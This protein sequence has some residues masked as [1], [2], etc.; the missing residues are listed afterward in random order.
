[1][2]SERSA[3]AALRTELTCEKNK[4]KSLLSQL[5]ALEAQQAEDLQQQYKARSDN[6]KK[7]AR[8]EKSLQRFAALERQLADLCL[9]VRDRSSEDPREHVDHAKR[10]KDLVSWRERGREGERE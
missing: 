1:M 5:R 10:R 2:P 7:V 9:E 8:L 4:V 6:A 3:D